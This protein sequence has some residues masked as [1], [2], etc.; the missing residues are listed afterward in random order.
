MPVYPGKTHGIA[1][2]VGAGVP[3]EE[4][5]LFAELVINSSI[6]LV[7]VGVR[8]RLIDPIHTLARNGVIRL[9]IIA[10]DGRCGFVDQAR[11]DFIVVEWLSGICASNR[12]RRRERVE[13][14]RAE[15]F[16]CGILSN[17]CLALSHV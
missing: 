2:I 7:A 6:P 13:D 12:I 16:S 11:R 15:W 1:W 4:T 8:S 9:R 17:D 3:A 14:D 10:G 5:M